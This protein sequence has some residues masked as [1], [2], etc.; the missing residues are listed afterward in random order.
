M[1]KTADF[2]PEIDTKL[3]CTCRHE[4]CDQPSID[5]ITLN[6]VQLIRNDLGLPI[7]ITS[8]GRCKYHPNEI[9]KQQPRDHT[10]LKAVDMFADNF[11]LAVKL[12]VLAG[13]HGAT[14]VAYSPRLKFVH[15]AWT[16][17]DR[18]D[19]PTWEY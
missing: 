18:T 12:I 10:G 3:L 4:L 7:V 13:R 14:R 1:I 9:G 15:A 5:Q 11:K 2:N 8:A 16:E 17:T 19:V 6:Q